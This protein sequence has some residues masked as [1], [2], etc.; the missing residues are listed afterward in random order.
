VKRK[1]STSSLA[2]LASHE[3]QRE[4]I[5][6]DSGPL[7]AAL[8]F[9]EGAGAGWRDADVVPWFLEHLVVPGR[10]APPASIHE[11]PVGAVPFDLP[12]SPDAGGGRT[13]ERILDVARAR[14]VKVL[15]AFIVAPPDDGFLKSAI[16][17]GRVQRRRVDGRAAW[18]ARPGESDSLSDIVLSLF[19]ADILTNRDFHEAML[20]VCDVC[21][22]MSFDP[23]KTTRVRCL[24][25]P[26]HGET[27]SGFMRNQSKGD[28]GDDTQG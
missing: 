14:V 4:H 26:P 28:P 12:D 2:S 13:M 25:H 24:A 21:G 6:D 20:C 5:V 23:M 18:V 10:M 3:S 7:S 8:T 11:P 15:R 22:R 1:P 17:S 9:V 19:A 27:T 16:Y